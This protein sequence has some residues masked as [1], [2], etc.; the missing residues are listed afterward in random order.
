MATA[1]LKN[2]F[3]GGG[4]SFTFLAG[5]SFSANLGLGGVITG[6][7]NVSSPTNVINLTGRWAI[8]SI[9]IVCSSP[10]TGTMTASLSVDGVNV[11]S[12]ASTGTA[13]NI[14]FFGTTGQLT[15][16]GPFS[17]QPS[18]LVC[19][20]SFVLTLQ[21]STADTVQLRYIAMAIE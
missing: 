18:P 3:G 4:G 15:S 1:N 8:T 10:G 19:N 16:G 12:G 14:P 13:Q 6:S 21:R 5:Q 17:G 11:L 9:E 2:L 7:I 20:S